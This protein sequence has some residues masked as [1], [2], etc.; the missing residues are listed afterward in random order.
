MTWKSAPRNAGS[1]WSPKWTVSLVGLFWHCSRS[2]LTLQECWKFMKSKMNGSVL[3]LSCVC[4]CVCVCMYVC[5]CV[6]VCVCARA[7]TIHSERSTLQRRDPPFPLPFPPLPCPL[8]P[9]FPT[10][11]SLQLT[12]AWARM[13][14]SVRR[15]RLCVTVLRNLLWHG[16]GRQGED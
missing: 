16:Q 13:Y 15:Q 12:T 14:T 11:S 7:C 1:L 3:Y 2:L 8:P 6:C 5:V 9:P 10:P 4:V